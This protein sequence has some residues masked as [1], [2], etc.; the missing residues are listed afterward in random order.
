MALTVTVNALKHWYTVNK[1]KTKNKNG[2][3]SAAINTL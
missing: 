1:K 2:S 3:I